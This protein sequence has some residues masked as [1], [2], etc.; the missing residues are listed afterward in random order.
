MWSLPKRAARSAAARRRRAAEGDYDDSDGLLLAHRCLDSPDRSSTK[1]ATTFRYL[2]AVRDRE[3]AI[4]E[5]IAASFLSRGG[6]SDAVPPEFPASCATD[7]S[8]C[9]VFT[10]SLLVNARLCNAPRAAAP[11]QPEIGRGRWPTPPPTLLAG[12]RRT[13]RPRIPP[14][15]EYDRQDG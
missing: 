7:P 2:R 6:G 15:E 13:R 12:R 5:A 10:L 3:P 14:R 1:R 11:N 9:A 4:G 8:V